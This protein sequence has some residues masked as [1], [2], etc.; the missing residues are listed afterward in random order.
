[1]DGVLLINLYTPKKYIIL[2]MGSHAKKYG[3]KVGNIRSLMHPC[4]F[5]ILY[6]ASATLATMARMEVL[7]SQLVWYIATCILVLVWYIATCCSSVIT[8]HYIYINELQA[9]DH[10]MH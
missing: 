9:D 5:F 3:S 1:M 2:E 7:I 8:I 10:P 4:I 6:R